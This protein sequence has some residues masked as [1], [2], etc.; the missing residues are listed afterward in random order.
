VAG[1]I[2][3]S[4][5][6]GQKSNLSISQEENTLKIVDPANPIPKYLQIRAWLKELIQSGRYKAGER[7]PS[8]M[9]LSEMCG[10]NRNT[11]RQAISELVAEGILRKEKGTGTFVSLSTPVA[12]KHQLRQISSFGDDLDGIGL[13]EKTIILN[14]GIEEATDSVAKALI[15]GS[16]NKVIAVRRLRTGNDIPFIYEESYLPDTMFNDILDMDLT[17]SMYKIM[18]EHFNIVLARSDQRIRA[19]N[20]KGKIARYLDVPEN[21][22]GLYMESITFNENNIPI[23]VLCAY[24]RGD[25]YV[26]EVEVGGYHIKEQ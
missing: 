15:L 13:Q 17:G 21:S 6:T 24:Y 23:E 5:D 16:H 26:F 20:L 11:L 18:S 7:L 14:R 10:V 8:E 22:A 9:E 19:V 2:C 25:K 12:L 3:R 1:T 4:I